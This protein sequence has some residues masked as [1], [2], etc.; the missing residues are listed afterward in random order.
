MEAI[1]VTTVEAIERW[2]QR[3]EA[4]LV[5]RVGA[6]RF[7]PRGGDPLALWVEVEHDG[8]RLG[9]VD[10]AA[11]RIGLNVAAVARLCDAGNGMCSTCGPVLRRIIAA[12]LVEAIEAGEVQA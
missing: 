11:G 6:L 10:R 12:R 9:G 2:E 8:R 7:V 4:Q 1:G 3:H 5:E